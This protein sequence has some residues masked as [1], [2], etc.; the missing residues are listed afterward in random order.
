[1]GWLVIPLIGATRSRRDCCVNCPIGRDSAEWGRFPGGRFERAADVTSRQQRWNR[2]PW[3]SRSCTPPCYNLGC[4]GGVRGD[5]VCGKTG[6]E[7]TR[8]GEL[9]YC[10]RKQELPHGARLDRYCIT[11]SSIR[12]SPADNGRVCGIAIGIVRRQRWPAPTSEGKRP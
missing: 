6:R 5:E 2:G 4:S 9:R 8:Y 3:T 11:A 7:Q 10:E 1:V 12:D